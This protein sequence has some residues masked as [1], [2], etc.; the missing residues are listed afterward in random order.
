MAAWRQLY[1]RDAMQGGKLQVHVVNKD[2][3]GVCIRKHERCQV[4]L[5]VLHD[6]RK[7]QGVVRSSNKGHVRALF[8]HHMLAL[9]GANMEPAM[10][11]CLPC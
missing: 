7:E 9:Q 4:G 11:Y 8:V 10:Q 5:H 3:N 1:S 6:R 2:V